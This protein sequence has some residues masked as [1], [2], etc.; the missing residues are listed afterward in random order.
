LLR[1]VASRGTARPAELSGDAARATLARIRSR[2]GLFARADL[3]RWMAANDLD[4][5]SMER[6]VEDEAR[7]E[8]LGER[9]RRSIQ[10]ALLDELR[11][12]GAYSRLADRALKK[13]EA[14]AAAGLTG[15]AGAPSALRSTAVRLWYF[16]NRLG[17]PVPD[18]VG[19]FARKVGFETLAAFDAAVHREWA[20]V[21]AGSTNRP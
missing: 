17:R 5:A 11:L 10:S 21:N 1:L 12:S 3:D 19:D 4:P 20:L 14:L 18:D 6:L 13:E 8:A 9:F 7:L 2:L 15:G 16:E